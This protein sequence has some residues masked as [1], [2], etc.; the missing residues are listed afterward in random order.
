MPL[1]IPNTGENEREFVSRCI[2]ELADEED[3]KR[4][5]DNQQRIAVCYKQWESKN[6]KINILDKIDYIVESTVSGDIAI[7]DKPL[8]YKN[9]FIKKKSDTLYCYYDSENN[10]I[11]C[12]STI[13][14]VKEG[15]LKNE[16][17]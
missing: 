13:K 10:E 9:G 8:Q 6:E 3:G 16:F 2:S 17:F 4:W 12:D 5:P 14:A 7:F 15:I 11:Y 1:P